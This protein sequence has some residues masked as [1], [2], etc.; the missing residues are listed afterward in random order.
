MKIYK[1]GG[2][3]VKDAAG[4]RNLAGILIKNNTEPVV[5]V[6]S[7]MGK[8]TN[9]FETIVAAY[10]DQK[11]DLKAKIDYTKQFHN[12][13]IKDLFP[14]KTTVFEEV[15]LIY[16]EL[17]SFLNRNESA[18]YHYVYDQVV[19][20]AE[21]ISTRICS[22]F[23]AENHFEHTWIDARECI[24][25]DDNY[26]RAK[27]DWNATFSQIRSKIHKKSNYLTQG[28]IAATKNGDT[29]TLGREGS[30][31]SAGIFAYCLNADEVTVFKDVPGVLNADP[32]RFDQTDL[33][34]QISYR[35]AIEMAF[36]GAS[37]IHPKTLQPLQQKNIPLYVRSFYNPALPG[38]VIQKGKPK[39]PDIPSFIVKDDQILVSISDKE[40]NFIMEDDISKIFEL[41]HRNRISVNLIQ[42]SA[43]SFSVCIEDYFNN[44]KA[45]YNALA[46]KYRVLYNEGLSLYTIRHYNEEAL[47]K[48][49]GGKAVL[50][51]QYSRETAQIVVKNT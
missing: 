14:D 16:D 30:D 33:L 18:G 17:E 10:F 40:F 31:Y 51:S 28:F 21:L 24:A 27:V 3:S 47:M 42:N 38:T 29:T 25:T 12:A 20:K 49:T 34:E 11:N 32:R 44:F 45:V 36:Y 1:F 2:A 37:V 48:I 39:Q 15:A 13:I 5:V 35:E 4:V 9:A 41:F 50:L 7:A 46:S 23:L 22:R 8:M 19:S 26:R 6:I 43:I